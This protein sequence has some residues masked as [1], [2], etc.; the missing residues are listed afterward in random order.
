MSE[1]FT[2]AQ[3]ISYAHISRQ[4]KMQ[5]FLLINSYIMLLRKDDEA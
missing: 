1:I 2:I 3:Q 4:Y 5:E